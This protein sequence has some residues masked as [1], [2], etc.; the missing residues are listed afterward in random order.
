MP[1]MIHTYTP[2]VF[3]ALLKSGLWREGDGLK[4]M[5]KPGFR[6]P[7]DFNTAAAVGSP[8]E[9]L[10]KELRCP[11]YIDR[12]Q[13]GMGYTNRYPY[14]PALTR[15]YRALLGDR[16]WGFQ[17]HE[18][19]SNF[20]SDR[21]RILA[22]ARKEGVRLTDPDEKARFWKRV[23]EKELPLFLEAYTA[24]EY[25]ALPLPET[26]GGFLR[27]AEALYA[28][29]ARETEGLL[30]PADSYFMAPRT[31]LKYGAKRLTPEMGWQIPELRI[32]TAYTRGM[33]RAAGV[34]WGVYYECWQRTNG[35]ALSIPYSLRTGQ[36]E[37]Q[38]DLLHRGCGADL[39]FERREHGGS[40][41][42]LMAR[43]WRYAY[44]SGAASF[45]EEYGVCNT[46]RSLED[47]TLSPYGETKREFLRFAEAFPDL[48]EPYTPMAVVLP[49]DL[50]MLDVSLDG[51]YLGWPVSDPACPAPARDPAKFKARLAAVFGTRGK[52]GEHSHV[53]RPGGLPG[54]FDIVHA[55]MT[56]ALDRYDHFIDLTGDPAFA[57]TRSAVTPEEADR[58][59][60]GLLPCRIG[61]GIFTAYNRARGCWYVLAMNND[62]ISHDGFLPD[63]KHPEATAAAPVR[64]RTPGKKIEKAAG[65][66]TLALDGADAQIRLEAGA[67][68]LLRIAE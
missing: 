24:E 68:I 28:L 31:E 46:F 64:L 52:Y 18:W 23:T 57:K 44:F 14:D 6:P 36:D 56:R 62:G 8:L 5:H 48:G 2:G 51:R 53:L 41:L 40:S 35:E 67:W 38:E 26:L 42:S 3:P 30:L 33:A 17:M 19:A 13:G 11:F 65:D 15:H 49:A 34:P 27:A 54:V 7:N 55:D 43:A 10:L 29:C 32:Q 25:A 1:A 45:A 60:D 66:G 61:G 63:V 21:E 37:W 59:L 16:F 12:L 39:P 20:N 58:I 9:R 47:A 4:L 22:L 50:P